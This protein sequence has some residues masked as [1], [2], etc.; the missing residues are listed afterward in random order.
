MGTCTDS[1]LD[2]LPKAMPFPHVSVHL[3]RSALAFLYNA[4]IRL[5]EY[6]LLPVNP[7]P[8]CETARFRRLHALTVSVD[9]EDYLESNGEKE[10]LFVEK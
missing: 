1:L 5:Y 8:L 2:K 4:E 9:N 3:T 10:I 6:I 7:R